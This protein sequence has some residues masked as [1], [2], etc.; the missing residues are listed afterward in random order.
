MKQKINIPDFG[1]IGCFVKIIGNRN[2]HIVISDENFGV[3]Y[4]NCV[5]IKELKTGE[6]TATTWSRLTEWNTNHNI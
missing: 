3:K 4:P 2:K 1:K 6:F 5:E